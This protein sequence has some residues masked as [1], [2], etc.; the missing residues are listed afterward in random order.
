MSLSQHQAFLKEL[1]DSPV[2]PK[3][4]KYRNKHQKA[5]KRRLKKKNA[6]STGK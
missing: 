5:A 2:D 6:S 4:K 3:I 1:T